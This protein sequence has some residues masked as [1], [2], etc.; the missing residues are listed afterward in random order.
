MSKTSA[1]MKVKNVGAGKML[2]ELRIVGV[3]GQNG[4]R[5]LK[6][7]VDISSFFGRF[8]RKKRARFV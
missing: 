2:V 6:Y 7:I 3:G 8:G 4:G 5:A 1:E